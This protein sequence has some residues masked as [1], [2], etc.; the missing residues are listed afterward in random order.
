MPYEQERDTERILGHKKQERINIK[1]GR[2]S[3]DQ[4]RE[5]YYELWDIPNKGL[6]LVLRIGSQLYYNKWTTTL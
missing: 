3:V 1:K 2:P 5:S 6:Y 4:V